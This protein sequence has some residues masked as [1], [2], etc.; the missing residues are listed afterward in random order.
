MQFAGQG[1]LIT[2]GAGCVDFRP[3]RGRKYFPQLLN[4]LLPADVIQVA[5][6]GANNAHFYY[7]LLASGYGEVARMGPRF[8]LL[9]H[10]TMDLHRPSWEFADVGVAT[11]RSRST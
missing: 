8:L 1:L 5:H 2:G 4:A 6:H 10:A 9:S 3:D 11:G 7:V